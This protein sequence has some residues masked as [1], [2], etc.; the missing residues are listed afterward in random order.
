MHAAEVKIGHVQ[1]NCGSQVF[2]RLAETR[3]KPSKTP[4][5][6]R[7]VPPGTLPLHAEVSKRIVSAGRTYP[8][9]PYNLICAV[10]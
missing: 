9:E 4:H 7:A 2:E 3:T 8:D 6:I 1:V 10:W 5:R